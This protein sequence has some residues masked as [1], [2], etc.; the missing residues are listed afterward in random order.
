MNNNIEAILT[1]LLRSIDRWHVSDDMQL[2]IESPSSGGTYHKVAS[3][4]LADLE[5]LHPKFPLYLRALINWNTRMFGRTFACSD[6]VGPTLDY[7]NTG[8]TTLRATDGEIH[9]F[10]RLDSI[11]IGSASHQIVT[12]SGIKIQIKKVTLDGKTVPVVI[13]AC[14]RDYYF[15]YSELEQKY[16]KWETRFSVG[17][18]LGLTGEDL[19]NYVVTTPI[20]SLVE[21][22]SFDF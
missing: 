15:P 12:V 19:L 3:A 17:S 20:V 2:T 18:Q 11:S 1:S 14:S 16:P 8:G 10:A 4:P 5:S 6:E 22:P 13:T 21:A 7:L 9:D